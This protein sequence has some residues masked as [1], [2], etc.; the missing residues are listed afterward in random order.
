MARNIPRDVAISDPDLHVDVD[1]DLIIVCAPETQF[2]AI[3]ARPSAMPQLIL[4][5][6][7]EGDDYELFAR[8]W[9]AANTKARELGWIA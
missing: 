2:I 7:T 9:Q 6:R 4:R 3:Y 1:G 5:K 8:A